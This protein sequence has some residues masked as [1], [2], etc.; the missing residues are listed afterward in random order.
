M[1]SH[2]LAIKLKNAG[3]P[4]GGE[5]ISCADIKPSCQICGYDSVYFPTLEELLD[6]FQSRY[7]YIDGLINDAQVLI[8]KTFVGHNEKGY[9]A[10]LEGDW[11]SPAIES[12]YRFA[13]TDPKEAV[14][15][16]WLAL[17]KKD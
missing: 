17:N 13:S 11:E 5:G 2:E 15:N 9:L 6:A 7:K 10:Y 12:I 3:F 4:Q 8:R 1:I 14:A 16:L